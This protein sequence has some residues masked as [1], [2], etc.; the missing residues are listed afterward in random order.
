MKYKWQG[1]RGDY[2]IDAGDVMDSNPIAGVQTMTMLLGHGGKNREQQL[3]GEGMTGDVRADMMN[4]R[5]N[6]KIITLDA[7]SS[8]LLFEWMVMDCS[9]APA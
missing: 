8:L 4:G 9:I 2:V 7:P 3:D 6:A 1:V 5:K